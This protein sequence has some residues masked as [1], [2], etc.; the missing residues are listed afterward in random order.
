MHPRART[1][2]RVHPAHRDTPHTCT[3]SPAQ[4]H[5]PT[6]IHRCTRTCTHDTHEHTSQPLG[7]SQ[8]GTPPRPQRGVPVPP[9]EP[10]SAC[11]APAVHRA[12]GLSGGPPHRPGASGSTRPSTPRLSRPQQAADRR[13]PSLGGA[14][15][16]SGGRARVCN[17]ARGPEVPRGDLSRKAG[18]GCGRRGVG[19]RSVSESRQ[20]TGG[21]RGGVRGAAQTGEGARAAPRGAPGGRTEEESG[22]KSG[23]EGPGQEGEDPETAVSRPGGGGG[24]GGFRRGSTPAPSGTWRLPHHIPAVSLSRGSGTL[25]VMTSLRWDPVPHSSLESEGWSPGRL[26]HFPDGPLLGP[27]CWAPAAGPLAMPVLQA[28]VSRVRGRGWVWGSRLPVWPSHASGRTSGCV[29]R[30]HLPSALLTPWVSICVVSQVRH[31]PCWLPTRVRA[32][33]LQAPPVTARSRGCE[34]QTS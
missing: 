26:G 32:R 15:A 14:G 27:R 34:T 11:V 5:P 4:T 18:G 33:P 13:S 8:E 28:L 17:Q 16:Q 6:H 7:R 10:V 22:N 25:S 1:C 30:A 24:G 3:D 31:V 9:A 2:A 20:P 23:N 29:L 19:R 21:G 12:Q